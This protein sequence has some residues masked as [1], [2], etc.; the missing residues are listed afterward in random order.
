MK[1]AIATAVTA[2]TGAGLG[3][4]GWWIYSAN[5]ECGLLAQPTYCHSNT[6][7]QAGFGSVLMAVGAV[8]FLAAIPVALGVAKKKEKRK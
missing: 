2:L 3:A 1:R 8:V 5:A 6:A 7:I 4:L